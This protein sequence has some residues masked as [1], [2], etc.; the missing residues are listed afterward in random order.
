MPPGSAP[1]TTFT[2]KRRFFMSRSIPGNA[3]GWGR[4]ATAV[5]LVVPAAVTTCGAATP[6]GAH[7][8]G[9]RYDL[10]LPLSL[11]LFGTAAAVGLSLGLVGLFRRRA[12]GARR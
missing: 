6:V 7:G 2:R 8:F 1:P 12:A 3:G 5:R 4:A 9:Q 11:Y 10:P